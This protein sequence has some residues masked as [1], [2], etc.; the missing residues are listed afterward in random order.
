MKQAAT[1]WVACDPVVTTAAKTEMSVA[2]WE[3]RHCPLAH[4]TG[5]YR[6]EGDWVVKSMDSGAR[7]SWS[8]QL[9]GIALGK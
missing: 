5:T 9:M 4:P 7:L 8:C 3:P 6:A 1:A 2:S